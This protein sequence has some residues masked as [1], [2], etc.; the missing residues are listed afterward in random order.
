MV[1]YPDTLKLSHLLLPPDLSTLKKSLC[2]P[3]AYGRGPG[4]L[5]TKTGLGTGWD[6]AGSG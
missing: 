5:V 3:A 1:L 2:L 6:D 4:Y